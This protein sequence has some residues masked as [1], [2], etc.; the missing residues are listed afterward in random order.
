[1]VAKLK[2]D[3]SLRKVLAMLFELC[4]AFDTIKKQYL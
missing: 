1:M 4:K 3:K 2:T